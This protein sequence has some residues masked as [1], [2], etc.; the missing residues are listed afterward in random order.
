MA[1]T[2]YA[3]SSRVYRFRFFDDVELSGQGETFPQATIAISSPVPDGPDQE[4]LLPIGGVENPLDMY[5]GHR[6]D[7]V[8]KDAAGNFI[9]FN[10]LASD[11]WNTL[12]ICFLPARYD[13]SGDKCQ[14]AFLHTTVNKD[15]MFEGEIKSGSRASRRNEDQNP[16]PAVYSG[17]GDKRIRLLGHWGS[18][19]FFRNVII[20]SVG[21]EEGLM[22]WSQII[23]FNA[24]TF[25]GLC[26]IIAIEPAGDK[27][28]L[29]SEEAIEQLAEDETTYREILNKYGT[30]VHADFGSLGRPPEFYVQYL[31][32]VRTLIVSGP[33]CTDNLI[34]I[35]ET[36]PF[37]QS[38][39]LDSTDVTD[40]GVK[41]LIAKKPD[42]VV[43]RSQRWAIQSIRNLGG[44]VSTSR[45]ENN[46]YPE[47]RQLIGDVHFKKVSSVNF[48]WDEEAH[49]DL[50]PI[51]NEDLMPL[52]YFTALKNL[53]LLNA[54][55]NDAGIHYLQGLQQV[56]VLWIPMKEVQNAEEAI[57]L[58]NKLGKLRI[59][60]A[61][62]DDKA[63][64]HISQ[65]PKL[66]QLISWNSSLTDA[67]LVHLSD[68]PKI[69]FLS[70]DGKSIRGD[71]FKNLIHLPSLKAL[72]IR[73][74]RLTD[75]SHIANI[76]S[77]TSIQIDGANVGDVLVKQLCEAKNLTA[78]SVK[79]GEI[80]DASLLNLQTLPNLEH[81]TIEGPSLS[82][83]GLAPLR[84]YPALRTLRISGAN[85]TEQGLE[86]YHY[87]TEAY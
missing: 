61:M 18:K 52:K 11:E 74:S 13:R 35:L 53:D 59:L 49:P 54:R 29:Y 83:A 82:D 7:Y 20:K 73:N 23:V 72:S 46:E 55:I 43:V 80:T 1:R 58:L 75:A 30:I 87:L 63:I 77:L 12:R 9:H 81:L 51:L 39:I 36:L 33:H 40:V 84:T 10:K 62:L 34:P 32:G 25:A 65:F 42:L 24:V 70:I 4:P 76:A 6:G 56:E 8:K 28:W 21:S 38:L 19:V 66:E 41:K 67:G 86:A 69:S 2:V 47:L 50:Q 68:L 57:I 27:L 22:R 48:R 15:T 85:I 14:N 26:S 79:G 16:E 64:R 31:L 5:W 78:V 71:G 60:S 3:Q 45:D 37:I 17:L 44:R